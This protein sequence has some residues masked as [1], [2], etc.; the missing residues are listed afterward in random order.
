MINNEEKST[1]TVISA[2]ALLDYFSLQRQQIGLSEFVSLSGMP[3]A[4]VLRHLNAMEKAGFIKQDNE[5]KKYQLGFKVMELA[6]IAKKHIKMRDIVLPYMKKLKDFTE[7]TVCLQVLDGDRGICIERL[8]PNNNLV[9]LP[10]IGSR[11]YLHGGASRKVL[12]NSC[13]S[14]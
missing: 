7:E 1:K 14:F 8:E 13:S 2:L 3:K 9:Y 10:P 6:Y 11:E 12:L 5:T 4:N